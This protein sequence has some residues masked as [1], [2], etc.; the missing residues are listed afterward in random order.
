MK[1]DARQRAFLVGRWKVEHAPKFDGDPYPWIVYNTRSQF[2]NQ[3]T[4]VAAIESGQWA[5]WRE[6]FAAFIDCLALV[7]KGEF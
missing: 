7:R 2:L 3:N 5:T 1:M 6:A 4:D